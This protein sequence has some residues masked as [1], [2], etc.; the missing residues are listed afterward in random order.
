MTVFLGVLVYIAMMC[1]V[2]GL[3][4]GTDDDDLPPPSGPNTRFA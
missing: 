4:K 1:L 3:F 2:L